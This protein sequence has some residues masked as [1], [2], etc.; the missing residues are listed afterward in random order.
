MIYLK[1]L[2]LKCIFQCVYII[3][4]I[5][6]LSYGIA[7]KS[8]HK[9]YEE[10]KKREIIESKCYSSTP[11]CVKAIYSDPDPSKMNGISYGC[12]KND[13][14]GIGIRSY[15]W[16]KNGCRHHSDYGKD[17]LICCCSNEDLCNL[18][19][20]NTSFLMIVITCTILTIIFSI[21]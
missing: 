15:G 10:F 17:G 16:D 7:C 11:F 9:Y 8:Y 6:P 4:I 14:V 1:K 20:K 13:C 3:S 19:K 12:D 21:L 18:S 5:L 2:D